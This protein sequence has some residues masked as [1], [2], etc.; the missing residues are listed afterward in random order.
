MRPRWLR[1]AA[2]IMLSLLAGWG[3]AKLSRQWQPVPRPVP[4]LHERLHG[5]LSLSAAQDE[6]IHVLE[7]QFAAERARLEADIRAANGRLA[8][9]MASEGRYGPAV[10]RAVDDIHVAMGALQ[11][12]SLEHVFA[13]RRELDARQRTRFDTII[14]ESLTA[15]GQ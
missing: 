7:R 4:S 11:K 14:A 8:V 12:A 9:A 3:G 1:L 5:E 13:M 6:R 15:P 10:A 2:I